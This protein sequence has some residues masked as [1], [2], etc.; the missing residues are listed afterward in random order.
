MWKNPYCRVSENNKLQN[1]IYGVVLFMVVGGGEYP[2]KQHLLFPMGVYI[3][4]VSKLKG[5][6][7]STF[8]S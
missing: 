7:V 5:S 1:N 3:P 8:V 6:L 2:S 4:Y